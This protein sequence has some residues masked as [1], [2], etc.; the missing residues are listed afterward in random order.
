VIERSHGKARPMLPRSSDL[1]EVE[2]VPSPT[3]G[4]S[5]G[6]RFGA[7]NSIASGSRWKGSIRKLLGKGATREEAESVARQAFRLYLALLRE[8]PSDGP[9]VRV[10]AAL[11]ARHAALAAHFTDR[12]GE[13]GFETDAG[14]AALETALKHGQRAERLAVTTLDVSTRLAAAQR[15]KGRG[16][17]LRSLLEGDDEDE[18]APAPAAPRHA[19]A[20]S[21]ARPPES[22]D[23]G[24]DA[25]ASHQEAGN[26]DE[27]FT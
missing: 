27:H 2:T 10:L 24:A 25:P 26:G 12:A 15:S 8:Q 13:L 6:G 3:E 11:E 18:P 9:T 14:A 19:P 23:D 17:A 22:A 16:R 4:R 7:G 1:R 20:L 5:E 21:E